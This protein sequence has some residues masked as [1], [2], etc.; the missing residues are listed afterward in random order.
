VHQSPAALALRCL[1]VADVG[2]RRQLE[3]DLPP[4]DG[5]RRPLRDLSQAETGRAS[6]SDTTS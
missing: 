4:A 3:V 2:R 5:R 1:P 6:A